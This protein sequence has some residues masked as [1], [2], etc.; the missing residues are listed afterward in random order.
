MTW[1]LRT[2]GR[3]LRLQAPPTWLGCADRPVRDTCVPCDASQFRTTPSRSAAPRCADPSQ[4]RVETRV[5]STASCTLP[6]RGRPSTTTSSR[7]VSVTV[8]PKSKSR[9]N[10]FV[11]Y[12]ATCF[13]ADACCRTLHCKTA[14][15]QHPSLR[16]SCTMVATRIQVVGHIG[17]YEQKGAG[18]GA[19]VVGEARETIVARI[20]WGR[21]W[22]ALQ[23][24][25]HLTQNHSVHEIRA[26]S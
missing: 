18:E 10:T 16:T 4:F 5:V 11:A 25:L 9:T 24:M 7:L 14:S 17:N 6:K 8:V 1:F 3:Q 23:K 2:N 26:F 19:D 20:R 13:S 15:S 12:S 21:S 22:M